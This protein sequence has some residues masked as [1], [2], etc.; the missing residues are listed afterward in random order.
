MFARSFVRPYRFISGIC[1]I[2]FATIIGFSKYIPSTVYIDSEQK[3]DSESAIT[4]KLD[5]MIDSDRLGAA[6]VV[7]FLTL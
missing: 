4:G 1:G 3:K 6:D 7:V 5:A 2:L